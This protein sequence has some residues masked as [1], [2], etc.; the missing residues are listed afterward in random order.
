MNNNFEV[1]KQKIELLHPNHF[2][3]ENSIYINYNTE[4]KVMC[5]KC[6]NILTIRP[7]YLSNKDS[8]E[9]CSFCR[10]IN[11]NK[12][13]VLNPNNN[14][15]KKV[16]SDYINLNIEKYIYLGIKINDN[17]FD[18]TL[19]PKNNKEKTAYWKCIKCEYIF[20]ATYFCLN[21]RGC[22]N[23]CN[24]ISKTLED[25]K[26]I[27]KNKGIYLGV[28]NEN[29][30]YQ[31]TQI[32]ISTH[33]NNSWWKCFSCNNEWSCSYTN[34]N[35]NKWC[36]ACKHKTELKIFNFLKEEYFD[37][38]SQY[39]PEFT[40]DDKYKRLSKYDFYIPNYNI[41]I[42]LHGEQHFKSIVNW[43][44][45]E[46]TQEKDT[47]KTKKL[48]ENNISLIIIYQPEVW[49]DKYDWKKYLKETIENSNIE[50]NKIQLISKDKNIYKDYINIF[51]DI[52]D[53]N[54]IRIV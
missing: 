48:L 30:E 20:L 49:H 53:I 21:T 14:T 52:I 13:V 18:S 36:P 40:K 6:N 26:N 54:T 16:L 23:C 39:T 32:P 38:I 25:Y 12:K 33:I 50:N 19:I 46:N 45:L 9:P 35:N 2:N 8:K 42:E 11:G 3:F 34:I 27:C 41:V 22:A 7:R 31:A 17:L 5:L 24:H 4:F 29:G 10:D 43:G 51:N 28:K 47:F 15:K 37:V 44:N 1:Y